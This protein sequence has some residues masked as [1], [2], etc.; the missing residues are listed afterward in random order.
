MQTFGHGEDAQGRPG[1]MSV[2]GVQVCTHQEGLVQCPLSDMLRSYLFSS[3]LPRS[4]NE[5]HMLIAAISDQQPC[6]EQQ[7]GVF[8]P[9]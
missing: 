2:F 7:I 1:E 9:S 8:V 4:C 3:V 5:T 6:V